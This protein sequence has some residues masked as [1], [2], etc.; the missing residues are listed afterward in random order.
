MFAY[1]VRNQNLKDLEDLK[2]LSLAH[3]RRSRK[4]RRLLQLLGPLGFDFA[5]L[6]Q[7]LRPSVDGIRSKA[8]RPFGVQ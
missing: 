2:D 7:T 3:R 4:D 5:Q 8:L 6:R 1:A